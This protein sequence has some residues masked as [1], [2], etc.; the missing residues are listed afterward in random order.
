MKQYD[1]RRTTSESIEDVLAKTRQAL[2][3][4]SKIR[5]E[6]R[7]GVNL[8]FNALAKLPLF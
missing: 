1:G 7:R 5:L 3:A 4:V 2:D 6:P 8:G